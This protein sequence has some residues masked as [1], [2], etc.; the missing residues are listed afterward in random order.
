MPKLLSIKNP[1]LTQSHSATHSFSS[2][3][4]EKR[5]KSLVSINAG[6]GSGSL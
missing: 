4:K 3:K 5:S 2:T 6:N 1:V